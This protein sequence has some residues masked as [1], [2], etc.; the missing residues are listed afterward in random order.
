MFTLSRKVETPV[1]S[2]VEVVTTCVLPTPVNCEP[3]PINV[4]A[5]TTPALTCPA[6]NCP[7]TVAI[8]LLTLTLANVV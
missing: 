3:L 5:V 2:N 4:V 7:A 6:V 1:T 8:P